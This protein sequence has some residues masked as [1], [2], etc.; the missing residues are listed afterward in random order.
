MVRRSRAPAGPCPSRMTEVSHI[1]DLCGEPASRVQ[2]TAFYALKDL[3]RGERVVLVLAQE[4][5]LMMQSLDLQL[6]HK[7]AWDCVEADGRWRVEVRH[8]DDAP[9]RDVIELLA[10]DHLCLDGL[11]VRALQQLNRGEAAAAAPLLREFA[12][13][14]RRHMQ[15]EDRLLAPELALAAAP[16][17]PL[18]AMLREHD[19]IR[20]Q[21]EAVE[22]CLDADAPE[23]GEIGAYCAIL[24][25]TLA[26][27]E[28]REESGLFALWRA[29]LN[30]LPQQQREALLARVGSALMA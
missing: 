23:A 18:E 12:A 9:P 5:S 21:L 20:S 25:G 8:R 10:R 13:A 29:A 6:R 2:G 22:E 30:H 24:S 7:L 28:Q 1:V 27:H 11:L 3:A 19:E 17:A 26:K 16:A 15:A 4:P 14:L